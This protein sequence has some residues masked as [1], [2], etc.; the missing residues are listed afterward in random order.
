M[1]FEIQANWKAGERYYFVP[2]HALSLTAFGPKFAKG[3]NIEYVPAYLTVPAD[4]SEM[5]HRVRIEVVRTK[6]E[7]AKTNAKFAKMKR[8]FVSELAD[9]VRKSKG[10]KK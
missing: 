4:K 6:K 3:F 2:K 10:A 7:A 5:Y 8:N 9:H 1:S